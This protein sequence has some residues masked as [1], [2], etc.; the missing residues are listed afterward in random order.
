[1]RT[2]VLLVFVSMSWAT[3]LDAQRPLFAPA[4]APASPVRV[5]PGSGTVILAD[6]SGDGHLDLLTRH[7]LGRFAT[8]QLG[9]GKGG[10]TAAPGGP[11]GFAYSPGDMKLGD[12]NNDGILDLAVTSSDRDIVDVLLGNGAGDFTP[13][14]GSPFTVST[15][16]ERFNK[17]SLH[18]VDL[19]EDG[20]LDVVTA[21]GRRR[22]TF[23]TLLGDGRGGFSPGPVV[24][25]DSDQD[26]YSF[27]FGDIDGDGHLDV[28]TASRGVYPGSG[29]I[30][31]QRGDGK[32]GFTNAFGA[33]L[34]LPPGPGGL[35]LADVNG[36]RRLDAVITHGDSL[37]TVLLNGGNGRLAPAAASPYNLG[38]PAFALMVVDVNRDQR[39]DLVAATVNSVT[40]LLGGSRG[41]L[42]APGSPF[43][44]GP[45]AYYIAVGDVNE[46]GKLDIAASSFEGNA[47]TV[48]LGR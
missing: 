25:L 1:M 15:S 41:F 17:R 43:G 13:V 8:V 5:G 33:P 22:N 31:P 4:P 38:A 45:G 24:R 12:L 14:A 29:R 21:N 6:V 34:S 20:N 46:D 47:V 18:L 7:S 48:L 2:T 35:T 40:V 27:A 44:A 37:L 30:V 19:D 26:G 39:P 32:G 10:F 36:D 9:D 11:L 28:V 23:A 42:P 16:V 3:R